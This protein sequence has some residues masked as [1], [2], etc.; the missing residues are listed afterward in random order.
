MISRVPG[1]IPTISCDPMRSPLVR[2]ARTR[3]STAMLSPNASPRRSAKERSAPTPKSS[4][5]AS[6]GRKRRAT[7]ST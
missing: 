5:N 1:N 7:N 2:K 6:P 4:M 3:T